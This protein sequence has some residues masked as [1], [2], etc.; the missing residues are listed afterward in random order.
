MVE[1]HADVYTSR[2]SN[3]AYTT[4]FVFLRS[5]RGSLPHDHG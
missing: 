2:V 5:L 3:L 4:P 1:S